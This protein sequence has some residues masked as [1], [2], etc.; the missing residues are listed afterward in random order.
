MTKHL[1]TLSALCVAIVT[2]GG[3]VIRPTTPIQTTQAYVVQ[4]P[5]QVVYTQPQVVYR[6]PTV[7]VRQPVVV[8]QPVVVRQPV[9]Y[10]SPLPVIVNRV[11]SVLNP[12]RI[13]VPAQVYNPV[14]YGNNYSTVCMPGSTQQCEAYCGYGVQYCN[15]DGSGWGSCVEGGYNY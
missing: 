2:V 4:Q 1:F 11:S 14:Y 5:T 12:V 3:C 13:S 6:Q 15:A 10:R 7:V 9:V 8:Q